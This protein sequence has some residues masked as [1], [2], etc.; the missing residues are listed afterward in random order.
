MKK[1]LSSNAQRIQDVLSAGGFSF[2]VVELPSSTRTAKAAAQTLKCTI[3]Q[4]VK[5]LVFRTKHSRKPILVLASGPN[6]VDESKIGEL[7]AE[8]IEKANADFVKEKTGFAIGGVSPI[9]HKEKIR[10]YID[11]DLLQ[12]Q[13]LWAA[14]GTPNAVFKLSSSEIERLTGGEVISIR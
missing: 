9:G 6:R 14:A 10:T 1:E 7:L 11:K 12:Y 8:P 4:I 2:D 5:S 3:E 13:E